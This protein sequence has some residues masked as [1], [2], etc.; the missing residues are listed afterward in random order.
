MMSPIIEG[1]AVHS[2][3]MIIMPKIALEIKSK[4]KAASDPS[5]FTISFSMNGRKVEKKSPSNPKI[6]SLRNPTVRWIIA[7]VG[8]CEWIFMKVVF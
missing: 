6:I 5:S 8:L 1:I 7:S 4:T 3:T 2:A